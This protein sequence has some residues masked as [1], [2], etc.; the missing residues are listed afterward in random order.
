LLTKSLINLY[1]TQLVGNLSFLAY[2]G[3]IQ[4][5]ICC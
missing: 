4:M 3:I 5:M 1:W 2:T